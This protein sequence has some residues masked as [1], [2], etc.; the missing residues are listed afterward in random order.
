MHRI[1]LSSETP[2]TFYRIYS[3]VENSVALLL[4]SDVS[5]LHL[6][7]E[8]ENLFFPWSLEVQI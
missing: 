2:R 6:Q 8:Y 1:M 3:H 7:G 4:H 5:A